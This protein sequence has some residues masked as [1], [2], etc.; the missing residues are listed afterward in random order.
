MT[1]L[2]VEILDQNWVRKAITGSIQ[3]CSITEELGE[4]GEAEVTLDLNDAIK[5][6]LPDPDDATNPFEGRFN[7]YEDDELKF[8]GVIDSRTLEFDDNNGT[9]HF[10]GKHRGILLGYYNLS[11]WDYLAWPVNQLFREFLRDNVAKLA[12]IEDISS[13]DEQYTG[14]QCVGGDPFKANYW[15]SADNNTPHEITI[16]LGRLYPLSAV[17]IM[18]QWW[19]DVDTKE[20]HFHDFEVRVSSDGTNF[21]LVGTKSNGNPSSAKGHLFDLDGTD[22][23]Y[24]K[25]TVTDS[26]DGYARIAQIVAYRDIADI[27]GDTTYVT[28]FVENDDSGNMTR[29]GTT[30]R[31]VIAGAFQGDDVITRSFVTRLESG[32]SI[33]QKFRGTSSAVYFTQAHKGDATARIYLDGV[34][35]GTIDIPDKAYG[36]KGYE[37]GDLIDG[38]HTLK[39]EQV[40][41]MVQVDYFSGLY[42]TSWRPIEDDDPSIA[43]LGSWKSVQDKHYFNYFSAKATAGDEMIYLFHG[44]RIRIMG[45]KVVGGGSFEM[46]IDGASQGVFSTSASTDDHKEVLADWSGSYD[47][48]SVHIIVNSGPVYLDRLEGNFTHTMYIRS[49][50]EANLVVMQR[51]AE[52]LDSYLRFNNDGSVDLLGSVGTLSGTILHEGDNEGGVIIQSSLEHDYT[53]TGSVVLGIVNV[54]GELPIK[55][56]TIDYDAI[57]EIGYKLIKFE[58]SDAADQFLLNRQA[59]QYLRDHRKPARSYDISFDPS[60]AGPVVVGEK[61]RLHAP[62]VNLHGDDPYRVGRITTEYEV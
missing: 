49:R 31:P 29:S 40:S 48:H 28:P 7:I 1:D 44:D 39:V 15:K 42:R 37:V 33:T 18:P 55:A 8:S 36:Y 30:S 54:N 11:R 43:Y 52:I 53:E 10:S 47:S 25:L 41:G 26:S 2:L 12:T 22:R 62:S 16:D 61:I 21:D 60:E 58:N 35:Q 14:A 17:R 56:L 20:F 23:R 9:I 4:V 50:Y 13:E 6:S 57:D 24:V 45:S 19:K 27:G 34:D 32:G 59:L 51:M 46:K 38:E 3:A 5:A